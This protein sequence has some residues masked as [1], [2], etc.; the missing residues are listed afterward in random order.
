MI[1]HLAN[2]SS[3][4]GGFGILRNTLRVNGSGKLGTRSSPRHARTGSSKSN[5]T[6]FSRI[7]T[8][9]IHHIF[10][11]NA[12]G[13]KSHS[14]LTEIIDS[15]RCR[16]GFSLDLQETRRV[17]EEEF[18]EN[19]YAFLGSGSDAQHGRGSCGVGIRNADQVSPRKS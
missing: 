5:R 18:P 2:A 16:N 1:D 4:S 17:D 9:P 13:L 10:Q 15:M 12:R 3:V 8:V 14:A 6:I 7:H 11:Q 19:N